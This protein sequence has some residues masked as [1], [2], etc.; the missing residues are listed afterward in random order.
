MPH[1]NAVCS[2]ACCM[3][4]V[5]SCHLVHCIPHGMANVLWCSGR[6]YRACSAAAARAASSPP[7]P[8][9][10]RHPPASNHNHPRH[11]TGTGLASR[12][13]AGARRPPA[14]LTARGA[15][16]EAF[17]LCCHRKWERT[18]FGTS[19]CMSSALPTSGRSAAG[20]PSFGG[21]TSARPT[22]RPWMRFSC[23]VACSG[24]TQRATRHTTLVPTGPAADKAQRLRRTQPSASRVTFMTSNRSRAL[25]GT[26]LSSARPQCLPARKG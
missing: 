10:A 6:P 5:A 24:T 11:C 4:H 13:R 1:C 20:A 12:P 2:A 8:T 21:G 7:T 16:S 18:G 19:A 17:R 14:T 15:E 22:S 23:C 25:Q 9:R 3:L 26:G